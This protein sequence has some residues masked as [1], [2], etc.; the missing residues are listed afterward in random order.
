MSETEMFQPGMLLLHTPGKHFLPL[1]S[2][3]NICGGTNINFYLPK[4]YAM[5][6]K[7]HAVTLHESAY[8]MIIK[9]EWKILTTDLE[10]SYQLVLV[11]VEGISQESFLG[12][13]RDR[14]K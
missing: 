11:W 1:A 14:R 2:A 10:R 6:F 8:C 13:T 12:V 5:S 4:L 9:N 3:Y 7:C